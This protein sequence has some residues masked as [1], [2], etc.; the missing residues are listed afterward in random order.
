[1]ERICF[2][3]APKGL[4]WKTQ[5]LLTQC[6]GTQQTCPSGSS[7]WSGKHP[8]AP[9]A[10]HAHLPARPVLPARCT[11]AAAPPSGREVNA[12]TEGPG[13]YQGDS[14]GNGSGQ[15]GRGFEYALPFFDNANGIS[16][17][18][19]S[20]GRPEIKL[21]RWRRGWGHGKGRGWGGAGLLAPWG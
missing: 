11:A 3:V 9:P 14:E 15:R 7:G 19:K 16:G 1:M 8:A 13:P 12:S 21:Q 2:L 10:G 17:I 6:S 4:L 5:K 18:V 20:T